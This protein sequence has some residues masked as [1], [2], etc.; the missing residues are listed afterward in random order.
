MNDEER[1]RP[2]PTGLNALN[3]M[4]RRLLDVLGSVERRFTHDQASRSGDVT[5]RTPRGRVAGSVGFT[6]RHGLASE[7]SDESLPVRREPPVP[8]PKI[9]VPEGQLI[10][11]FDE[12]AEILVTLAP[13][14]AS[15]HELVVR[16]E[17]AELHIE[18]T[19]GRRFRKRIHLPLD[20]GEAVPIVSLSNGILGIRIPKPAAPTA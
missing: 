20:L 14:V 16:I 3:E 11:V 13:C 2:G 7:P 1:D 18:T 12:P 5:I 6:I 10:D 15:A 17:G 4:G 8:Q 19:G 9:D